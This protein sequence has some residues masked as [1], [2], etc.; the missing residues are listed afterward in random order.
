M[1]RGSKKVFN[2][3]VRTVKQDQ[4]RYFYIKSSLIKMK[5][6]NIDVNN[7]I[8][9]GDNL[10]HIALKLNNLKLFKLF[11]KSGVNPN[12]ANDSCLAP[13]H[14]AVMLNRLDFIKVLVN[15]NC[16]I[17][18]GSEFE[19]TPLHL[20]VINGN[21]E[22]VKYLVDHNCSI[23]IQDENNNYPI[24]YAIDEEDLKMIQYFL[25]KQEVDE[26]RKNKIEKIIK[27]VG[28]SSV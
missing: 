13:I 7:Q 10:L 2:D 28:G 27:K 23:L 5:E 16:D 1:I 21:L 22:I 6:Q 8:Y 24:D 25:S 17:D 15:N 14:L 11:L 26:V 12:L 20:A 4:F 9:G 18:L 19:Q 3:F